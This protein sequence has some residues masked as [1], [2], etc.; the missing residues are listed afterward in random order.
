MRRRIAHE[1]YYAINPRI[2]GE[3][4]EKSRK[5]RLCGAKIRENR[6]IL[7]E[8]LPEL[9]RDA[10]L[11]NDLRTTQPAQNNMMFLLSR[12]GLRYNEKAIVPARRPNAGAVPGRRGLAWR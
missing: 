2:V 8:R 6:S 5:I 3:M 9:K 1:R 7:G 12:A 11:D 10:W 4:V